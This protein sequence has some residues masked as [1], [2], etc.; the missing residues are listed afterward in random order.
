MFYE[1]L[2]QVGLHELQESM[3]RALG[4]AVTVLDPDGRPLTEPSNLCSFCALLDRNPQAREI[5]ASSRATSAKSAAIKRKEVL[6]TCPAGLV[7][8]AVPLRVDGETVA[9]VLGGNIAL[10]P[11]AE[12]AVVRLAR[13][14]GMDPEKLL[15]AARAVPLWTEERLQAAMAMVQKVT[16][17]MARLLY[18]KQE[19]GRKADELAALFEF[20]RTVSGSLEVGEV[21]RR[22]LGSVLELTGATSGSV[23]MLPE[24]TSG[25]AAPEVAASVDASDEL[26]VTPPGEVVAT[27]ERETRAVHFGSRPGGGTPGEGRPGVALPLTVGGRVTG[28]LTVAGK[29]EGA[30]FSED[31]TVLLTTLG[32]SLGLALE[33]ARLFRELKLRAAMLERLIGVGRVISGS[34]D[35]DAVVESALESVRE[36]LG[37]ERCILRL[38]DEESGEL[39]LKGSRGT[40]AE[41]Q[42]NMGRVRPEGTVLGKVLETGEPVVVEDLTGGGA[43]VHLPYYPGEMRALAVVPVRAGGKVLGTLK[44]YSTV[45]RRWTV[46]EL[47]YLGVVASQTG[48]ALQNAR[49]YSSLREYYLSAVRALAAA[50]EAKDVYT[51]GHSLRV[52]RWAQACARVLGLGVEEQEQVY[53]A[54][55]LHDLGKIGVRESILLKPGRLD[56]EERKEIEWHPVIGARILEPARFP[57]VVIQA[58]RH[59][60]EDY[61]GRGYPGGL[62]GEEIPLLARI[63]RVADAYDAMTSARPYREALGAQEAREE[64]RRYAG[65]QFDPQV[66]EAFLAIPVE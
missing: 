19:L 33:N 24:T 27:V 6:D 54:G 61:D 14:A 26:H 51:R 18:A 52:A 17:T 62:V 16:E 31:E 41:L 25:T 42:A 5:C 53:L 65:R 9:V 50:L 44:I 34:L 36:V 22:A 57:A 7:H 43:G 38:L 30:D 10:R 20:S 64:L 35:V 46:E 21:A 39:V 49:L 55:L 11:L 40:G 8:L 32:T 12:E 56:E 60:H 59:H 29:P 47:G 37:A 63:L 58:V 28:V 48:L 45:P 13:E 23:I 4:L 66:V 3:S 2:K 1:E 15:E